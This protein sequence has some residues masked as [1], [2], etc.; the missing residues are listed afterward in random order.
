MGKNNSRKVKVVPNEVGVKMNREELDSK[1]L[2]GAYPNNQDFADL[3]SSSFNQKDDGIKREGAPGHIKIEKQLLVP[4]ISAVNDCGLKLYGTDSNQNS[5]KAVTIYKNGDFGI[6]T[7]GK[8]K[9]GN[10]EIGEGELKVL[11]DLA[12]SRLYVDIQSLA[13]NYLENY[14]GKAAELGTPETARFNKLS[15]DKA[16]IENMPMRLGIINDKLSIRVDQTILGPKKIIIPVH[17]DYIIVTIAGSSGRFGPSAKDLLANGT[18]LV[19][20]IH[21]STSLGTNL[22]L[23]VGGTKN[24]SAYGGDAS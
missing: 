2:P 20:V 12:H 15:Q 24:D 19:A 1:F 6:G 4:Q 13:G 10:T 5:A 17:V 3:I 18:I 8:F 11:L 22:F 16:E 21:N 9:I 7:E 23:T 14:M